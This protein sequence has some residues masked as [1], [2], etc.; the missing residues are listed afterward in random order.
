MF[1]P[2]QNQNQRNVHGMLGGFQVEMPESQWWPDL[3]LLWTYHSFANSM[4]QPWK[5]IISIYTQHLNRTKCHP[6]KCPKTFQPWG[7]K[8]VYG[9]VC[10][11][12]STSALATCCCFWETGVAGQQITEETVNIAQKRKITMTKKQFMYS[13]FN[14]NCNHQENSLQT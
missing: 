1:T 7:A 8:L 13:E 6:T 14:P 9:T 10:A 5:N 11:A 4:L 2:S 12:K 3:R